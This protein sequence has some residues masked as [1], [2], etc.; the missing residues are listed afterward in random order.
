[1]RLAVLLRRRRESSARRGSSI[2]EKKMVA[3]ERRCGARPFQLAGADWRV[4]K[5][6]P[7]SATEVAIIELL[8]EPQDV[9]TNARMIVMVRNRLD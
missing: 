4:V 9:R 1:V 5:L 2:R 6:V 3:R 7:V 8:E